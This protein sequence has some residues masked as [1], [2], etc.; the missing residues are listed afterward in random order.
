VLGA[1]RGVA[2]D[3]AGGGRSPAAARAFLAEALAD[4]PGEHGD[5]ALGHYGDLAAGRDFKVWERRRA[6]EKAR[7]RDS[8]PDR[9]IRDPPPDG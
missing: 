4:A 6:A 1:T 8:L 5:P 7:Q 9:T 2:Y 3:L